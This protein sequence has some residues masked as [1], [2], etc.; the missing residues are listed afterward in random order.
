MERISDQLIKVLETPSARVISG[1]DLTIN[2]FAIPNYM[3][4][5]DTL[6]TM[7]FNTYFKP[8]IIELEDRAAIP[9]ISEFLAKYKLPIEYRITLPTITAFSTWATKTQIYELSAISGVK[10]IHLNNLKYPHRIIPRITAKFTDRVQPGEIAS[11]KVFKAMGGEQAWNEGYTGKPLHGVIIDSGFSANRMLSLAEVQRI[12][13]RG[14]EVADFIGHGTFIMDLFK[15]NPITL[16]TG[17]I[18]RG[19]TQCKGTMIKA[20]YGGRARDSW[21]LAALE[22]ALQLDP[23]PDGINL[24]LGG[25]A[26]VPAEESLLARACKQIADNENILVYVSAGNDGE[27]DSIN[28]PGIEPSVITVGS[29]SYIKYI[30]TNELLRSFYSSYGQPLDC[31][32]F[33]GGQPSEDDKPEEEILNGTAPFSVIDNLDRIPNML[34]SG[35]GTSWSGP[36]AWYIAMLWRQKYLVKTGMMLN[37]TTIHEILQK[38]GSE[39][40]EEIGY[41]LHHWNLLD[42]YI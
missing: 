31:V 2:R 17:D 38:N 28:D 3:E 25:T 26:T 5:I 27:P 33:G 41:G 30:A 8:I 23:K 20:L 6:N 15:G 24:S 7:G 12:S 42:S 37:N 39:Y 14:I 36:I 10:Q 19:G 13:V 4:Y 1:I 34:G 11:G 35:I 22:K 18:L 40:S 16:S 29:C 32:A 21:I 9:Q